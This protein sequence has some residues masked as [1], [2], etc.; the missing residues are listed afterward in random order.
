MGRHH[1]ATGARSQHN[2][3]GRHAGI[4]Q[5]IDGVIANVGVGDSAERHRPR[6]AR[7]RRVVWSCAVAKAVCLMGMLVCIRP[8]GRRTWWA[9]FAFTRINRTPTILRKKLED[10]RDA[11]E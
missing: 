4:L 1:I 10:L 9:H 2:A 5:A 11:S 8:G 6:P 3:N 7:G